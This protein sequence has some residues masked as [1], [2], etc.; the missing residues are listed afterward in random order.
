MCSSVPRS[1]APKALATVAV[2]TAVGACQSRPPV[3]PTPPPSLAA[4]VT[5]QVRSLGSYEQVGQIRQGVTGDE[6]ESTKFQVNLEMNKC[7]AFSAA[8]DGTTVDELKIYLFNP[9]GQRVMDKGSKAPNLTA[10]FCVT[11]QAVVNIVPFG[12][13]SSIAMAVPGLYEVELKTTEGYGHVALGIFVDSKS[14]T[15]SKPAAPPAE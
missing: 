6:D 7:Y 13:G 8:A 5:Q 15:E 11:G 14:N 9:N 3:P 1:I 4:T 2:M 12:W 10:S